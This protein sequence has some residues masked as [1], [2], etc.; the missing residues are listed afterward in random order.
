MTDSPDEGGRGRHRGDADRSGV[1]IKFSH[2]QLYA[3]EVRDV[4]EYKELE[5]SMNEFYESFREGGE[6]APKGASG[7]GRGAAD[8]R[9]GVRLWGSIRLRRGG[10]DAHDDDAAFVPH[11]RDVV[12]VSHT[13]RLVSGVLVQP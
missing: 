6:G 10:G 9:E 1:D 2:V 11:G 5:A 8:I 13:C 3:D 4:A 12:K 7:G